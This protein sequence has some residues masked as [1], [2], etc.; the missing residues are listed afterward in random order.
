MPFHR[1]RLDSG[2]PGANQLKYSYPIGLTSQFYFCGMPFRIDSYR[3]CPSG[4]VYCFVNSRNGNYR[5]KMQYADIALLR[6]WFHLALKQRLEPRNIIIECLRRRMP[7]HFG[8]ISDPLLIPQSSRNITL[9]ILELLDHYSYPTLISTKANIKEFKDFSDIILRKPHFA[10]QIS[11]S[12]MNDAV[13]KFVEPN[14][15]IPSQRM[16]GASYALENG[17]WVACRL[18]P[19]FPG[20]DVE[21]LLARINSVG[22]RHLTI[23]HFKLPFDGK[24]N[25]KKLNKAFG[26]DISDLFPKG[27]RIKRGREFEM[28]NDIRVQA[29]RK[30]KIA[31]ASHNIPI[32]IGDNGFQHLSTSDCCC[33]IDNLPGFENWY[34]YTITQAV[35]RA[36]H[37]ENEIKY[38]S[39]ESEWAPKNSMTRML[40]SKSR[41]KS[42]ANTVRDHIK[43]HWHSN[44][45]F[46]PAMFYGVVYRRYANFYKYYLEDDIV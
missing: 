41:L 19:Y 21:D 30:F 34:K 17:N 26:I 13:G 43:L 12:T 27:E 37:T 31:A 29:I 25:L 45:Q 28:P 9:E 6:K 15:P 32:G 24:V 14:A 10:L 20:Q 35:R 36:K 23:E 11:F 3:G 5:K 39:I 8:G 22:F 40:N 7:L 18:Q 33:G 16:R 2:E 4:C 1:I 42:S 38:N 46:S 44:R